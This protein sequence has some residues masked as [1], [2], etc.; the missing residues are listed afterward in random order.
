MDWDW[1]TIEP[2]LV[3]QIKRKPTFI[4]GFHEIK[5]LLANQS[6]AELFE[7]VDE[8]RLQAEFSDW[9]NKIFTKRFP[10]EVKSLYFGLFSMVEADNNSDDE[11][12]TVYFCGST[13]TPRDDDDWACWTDNTYLPENKYLV[14]TDFTILDQ[15]INLNSHI[16]GDLNV[17]IFHGLL[18]LLIINS[19][20]QA[21]N[22]LTAT[23]K[24]LYLGSG[25]DGGD[26]LILGKLTKTGLV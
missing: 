20:E 8:E 17:L 13:S 1:D 14:L 19:L 21:N 5:N 7:N 16:E 9:V 24:S 4:S 6:L 2:I 25:Y 26:I 18:N 11:I 15:N 3:D 10:K 12:T 22:S 23:H